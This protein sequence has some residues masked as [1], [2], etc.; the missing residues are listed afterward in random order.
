MSPGSV[1]CLWVEGDALIGDDGLGER[2]KTAEKVGAEA[3][4]RLVQQ[5]K[6]GAYV[7]LHTAD[8]LILPC[9]LA[10]GTSSFTVSRLTM[11]TLTAVEVAKLVAGVKI[12][13]GGAEG[14]LG[15]ITIEG[16]GAVNPR[17]ADQ[18]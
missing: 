1:I 12:T 13:V 8:N 9:S 7:D 18:V 11:H 15:K 3:A 17:F 14:K 5:V 4:Q 16:R 2:G 6:T 10:S